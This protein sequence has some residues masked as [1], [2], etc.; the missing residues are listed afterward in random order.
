MYAEIGPLSFHHHYETNKSNLF[1]KTKEGETNLLACR[2][3]KNSGN[4]FTIQASKKK[5]YAYLF[6]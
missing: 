6:S 3:N 5:K 1:I 4:S 2:F